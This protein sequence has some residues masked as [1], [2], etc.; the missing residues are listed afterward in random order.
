MSVAYQKNTPKGW[1][2]TLN[3]N[4]TLTLGKATTL[5]G[6]VSSVTF[7]QTITLEDARDLVQ[8]LLH[9]VT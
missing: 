8:H 6:S 3:S 9:V 1:Q 2:I 7:P 5:G 4:G